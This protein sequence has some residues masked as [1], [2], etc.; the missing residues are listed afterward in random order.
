MSNENLD[1]DALATEEMLKMFEGI[2][3]DDALTAEELSESDE[4]LDNL[5]LNDDNTETIDDVI[6][7]EDDLEALPTMDLMDSTD[8]E[9]LEIADN[10]ETTQLLEGLD[11]LE[12]SDELEG[13]SFDGDAD[14]HFTQS[15]D[16]EFP[17]ADLDDA[18]GVISE[19]DTLEVDDVVMNET[20][21][22]EMTPTAIATTSSTVSLNDTTPIAEHLQAV[23]ANAIQALQDWMQLRQE[24]EHKGPQQSLAQL[25]VLLDTVTNQQQQ[26]AEQLANSPQKQ[27]TQI[28]SALGVTL[29]TPQTLGWTSDDWRV[30]AQQV[31]D[32]T[33]DISQRNAKIRQELARL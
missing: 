31:A 8:A 32:K 27:L 4:L 11:S 1:Q 25:D 3:V 5:S 2:E 33:D 24:G 23:V 13:L 9:L 21:P 12:T 18:S 19:A 16:E 6:A 30:K 26:L 29:A 22:D 28:S 17:V 7:L 20:N 10:D 15:G 14:E